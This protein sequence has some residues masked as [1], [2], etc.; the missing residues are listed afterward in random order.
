M[1]E[2]F[3]NPNELEESGELMVR[4]LHNTTTVMCVS[5]ELVNGQISENDYIPDIGFVLKIISAKGE[6]GDATE[7]G[8][9]TLMTFVTSK[10]QFALLNDQIK[11]R[12]V[13]ELESHLEDFRTYRYFD[14]KLLGEIHRNDYSKENAISK[15]KDN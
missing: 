7:P 8:M 10:E 15:V 6:S 9:Y 1:A 14:M 3:E 11:N 5:V 2:T 12:V 13:E 4:T